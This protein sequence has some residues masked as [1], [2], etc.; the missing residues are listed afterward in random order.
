VEKKNFKVE[1]TF[2]N[3]QGPIFLNAEG[4]QQ[5]D[6]LL[7]TL[8]FLSLLFKVQLHRFFFRHVK[9]VRLPSLSVCLLSLPYFY[10][11]ATI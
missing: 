10:H 2:K 9:S 7:R 1:S 6:T 3:E 5:T 11:T 8:K 4:T